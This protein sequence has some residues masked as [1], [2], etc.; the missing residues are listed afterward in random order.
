MA[1]ELDRVKDFLSSA[2]EMEQRGHRFYLDATKHT[3]SA[4]AKE[5]FQI[6]A[7]EELKHINAFQDIFQSLKAGKGDDV[8]LKIPL[9]SRELDPIF[10]TLAKKYLKEIK[11]GASRI[12]ALELGMEMEQSSIKF[13]QE[14][15][16]QA[17]GEKEREFLEKIIQEEQEHFQILKDME[18][19]FTNPEGWF[20][21]KERSSLDGG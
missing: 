15:L 20:Q 10:R 2:L 18:F 17:E 16:A 6:L 19:Y 13:Y 14:R 11:P 7:E 5:I 1:G 3:D 12:S 4:L 8:W 9:Q 21:E